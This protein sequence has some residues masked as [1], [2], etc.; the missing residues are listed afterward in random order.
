MVLKW[1][2]ERINPSIYIDS[3][4]KGYIR[5]IC[6]F[7]KLNGGLYKE[8]AF[9]GPARGQS[10]KADVRLT[11]SIGRNRPKADIYVLVLYCHLAC[12][13]VTLRFLTPLV[14]F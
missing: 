3:I 7:G 2:D 6:P 11:A 1:C 5:Y 8:G 4:R 14:Q 13:K 10:P 12:S 9:K